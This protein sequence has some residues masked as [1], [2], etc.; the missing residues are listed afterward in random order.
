[1]PLRPLDI[2]FSKR[3]KD[4]LKKKGIGNNNRFAVAMGR[5]ASTTLNWWNGSVPTNLSDLHAI[6]ELL[7]VSLDELLLGKKQ[8]PREFSLQLDATRDQ[9]AMV[10]RVE[11]VHFLDRLALIPIARGEA[12]AGSPRQVEEDPAG[13][14]VVYRDWA[15]TPGNFT[16]LWVE[17]D[18][19]EPTILDG[20]L[21]GIDHSRRD[22]AMLQGK[23]AAFREGGGVTLKRVKLKPPDILL[24]VPD[25]PNRMDSLV[26]LKG[27]EADGAII[28]QAVWGWTRWDK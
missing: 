12:A 8:E 20:S 14:A 22:P 1:M 15:R 17:G 3:L 10:Q 24:G 7:G 21:V 23:I 13:V 4:L 19:M 6:A 26:V 18:S 27:D 5:N 11:G 25:N 28:G 2:N 16:A 9:M